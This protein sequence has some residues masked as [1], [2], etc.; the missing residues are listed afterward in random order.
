MIVGC[1]EREAASFLRGAYR[2]GPICSLLVRRPLRFTPRNG[3]GYLRDAC[4]RNMPILASRRG[5]D[6]VGEMAGNIMFPTES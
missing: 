1:D 4:S 5:C 2:G 6:F 3:Q